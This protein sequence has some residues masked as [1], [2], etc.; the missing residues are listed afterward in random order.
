MYFVKEKLILT[1]KF[2]QFLEKLFNWMQFKYVK[3]ILVTDF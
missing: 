3:C 1:T 2:K